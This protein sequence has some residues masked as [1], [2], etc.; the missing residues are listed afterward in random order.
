MYTVDYVDLE[1]NSHLVLS[2]F[3]SVNATSQK[4]RKTN[5]RNNIIQRQ[6]CGASEMNAALRTQLENL[7]NKLS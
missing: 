3:R 7:R 4:Q 1:R 2:E 6:R 5:N